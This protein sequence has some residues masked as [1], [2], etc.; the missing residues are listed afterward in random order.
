[1]TDPI[2]KIIRE[3]IGAAIE[4]GDST[5]SDAHD[6]ISRLLDEIHLR[7]GSSIV[8][9]IAYGSYLRGKRDTLL[10]FYVLLENFNLMPE[11][12]HGWSARVLPPNVYN[13]C[14]GQIPNQARAKYAA[15]SLG[16]FERAMTDHFHSYF[17]ARFA[18]PCRLVY[19]K[20]AEVEQR[21]VLSLR[22]ATHTFIRRV[23]PLVN[24]TFSSRDLW[25]CGLSQTYNC[26]LRTESEEQ[27]DKLIDAHPAYFQAITQAIAPEFRIEEISDDCFSVDV[28][29]RDQTTALRMWRLRR[30]QGK[31]L[32]VLRIL[33]AATTFDDSLEYLL[34]KI[35][36]HSGIYIKP[37]PRQTRFP[38]IFAWGLLWRLYRLG[39]FR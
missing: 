3:Q 4:Q 28:S 34:W 25:R 2:L 8:A 31:C 39:A 22:S 18:Q 17:W 35:E 19:V 27:A 23:L 30:W 14:V 7:H 36:R 6:D 29:K 20:S 11:R 15:L 33:K 32:S 21:I 1:M 26:E 24:N 13:V 10:D 16:Q 12:W 9:V 5:N 38:L 37:S